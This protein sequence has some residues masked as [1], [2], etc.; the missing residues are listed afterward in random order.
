MH[1]G[2]LELNGLSIDIL[3]KLSYKSQLG[4]NLKRIF[5]ILIKKHY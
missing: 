4:I 5:I 1:S 2:I 3:D